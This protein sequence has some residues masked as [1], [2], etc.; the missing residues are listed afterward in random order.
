MSTPSDVSRLLSLHNN[1][2]IVRL[3]ISSTPGTVYFHNKEFM[4]T[5]VLQKLG[6]R[7]GVSY[8]VTHILHKLSHT[9]LEVFVDL[10]EEL[11][12]TYRTLGH[13]PSPSCR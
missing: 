1:M 11:A 3:G 7:E 12:Q 2:Y 5:S 10:V 4:I 6:S 8:S 9:G 13:S